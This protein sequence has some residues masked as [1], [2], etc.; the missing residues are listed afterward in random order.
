M[1]PA[2]PQHVFSP[3]GLVHIYIPQTRT[4][5]GRVIGSGLTDSH[6]SHLHLASPFPRRFVISLYHTFGGLSRGFRHFYRESILFS[7]GPLLRTSRPF[8]PPPLD[9]IYYITNLLVCQYF[10]LKVKGVFADFLW[11]FFTRCTVLTLVGL[12]CGEPP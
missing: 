1:Y 4:P 8:S 11:T 12:P 2:Y 7:N 5:C 9:Y 10:F 3:R 6:G